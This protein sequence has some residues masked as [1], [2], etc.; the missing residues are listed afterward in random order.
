[1]PR[2]PCRKFTLADIMILVA[3]T[4]A[5]FALGRFM[6][7][8][9]NLPQFNAYPMEA[10]SSVLS[11]LTL[12]FLVLRLKHPRPAARVLFRHPGSAAGLVALVAVSVWAATVGIAALMPP[13]HHQD[14]L[15]A[16]AYVGLSGGAAV[17]GAWVLLR[18]TR[19]GRREPG[20]ID[21]LGLALGCAWIALMLLVLFETFVK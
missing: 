1:M 2:I 10:G 4:A 20:W 5:G 17:L 9:V 16:F 7:E 18:V 21:R 8:S 19:M 12:G 15:D 11:T 3:A 6:L 14:P 13:R